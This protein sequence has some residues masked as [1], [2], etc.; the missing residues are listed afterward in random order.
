MRPFGTCGAAAALRAIWG[1]ADVGI[2]GSVTLLAGFW[3]LLG[4]VRS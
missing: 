4:I 1:A 3:V 2:P